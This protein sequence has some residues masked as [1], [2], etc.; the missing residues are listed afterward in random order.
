MDE[1]LSDN[2]TDKK[3]DCDNTHPNRNSK[4]IKIQYGANCGEGSSNSTEPE[5]IES[6]STSNRD[7]SPSHRPR[8]RNYR[9]RN[10][11][12]SNR[13]DSSASANERCVFVIQIKN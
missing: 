6:T 2:Y 4:R 10:Y 3:D 12:N 5:N 9:N 7:N 13:D 8:T 1:N 11:R